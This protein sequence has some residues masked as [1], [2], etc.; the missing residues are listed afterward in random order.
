M[1]DLARSKGVEHVDGDFER[2]CLER[3]RQLLEKQRELL[4]RQASE[5]RNEF[6]TMK[7]RRDVLDSPAKPTGATS[8]NRHRIADLIDL[9]DPDGYAALL[10]DAIKYF[11][12]RDGCP[13]LGEQCNSDEARTCHCVWIKMGVTCRVFAERIKKDIKVAMATSQQSALGKGN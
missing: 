4:Q 13:Y 3:E 9:K 8:S 10:R 2:E 12:T 6:Q 11:E 5:I 1:G 7:D